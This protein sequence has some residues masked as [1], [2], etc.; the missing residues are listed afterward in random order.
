MNTQ[1]KNN[2]SEGLKRGDTQA[3]AQAFGVDKSYVNKVLSGIRASNSMKAK[4][5]LK[6]CEE[7]KKVN[8]STEKKLQ[9][10]NLELEAE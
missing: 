4:M 3:I 10:L 8:Q 2:F 7:L 5:I 9:K 6:A 1:G